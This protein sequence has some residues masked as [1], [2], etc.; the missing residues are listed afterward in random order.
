MALFAPL[1]ILSPAS[2]PSIAFCGRKGVFYFWLVLPSLTGLPARPSDFQP[3][4]LF[5]DLVDGGVDVDGGGID[6]G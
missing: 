5:T 6:K 2:P 4:S 3:V 1:A